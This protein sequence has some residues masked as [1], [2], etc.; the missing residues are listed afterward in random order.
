[1]E[2]MSH[3]PPISRFLIL[4]GNKKWKF[5]GYYE[6]AVKI[7]SLTGNVVGGQFKGPNILEI[8]NPLKGIFD[9]IE[10]TLPTMNISGMLYGKRVIEWEGI[11][12]FKDENNGIYAYLKFTPAPKFYQK[13]VEPTDIFRGEITQ[14]EQI[15]HKIYGS[16]LEKIMFDDEM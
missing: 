16:P 8:Y 3:H 15:I 6:Y 1:M 4:A 9:V 13:F 11:C 10:Y 7:K 2:H 12:E 5:H 14:N